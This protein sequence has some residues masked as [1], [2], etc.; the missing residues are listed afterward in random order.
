MKDRAVHRAGAS[1]HTSARAMCAIFLAHKPGMANLGH[2]MKVFL[3]EKVDTT[4]PTKCWTAS[5]WFEPVL[6]DT[7]AE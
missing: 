1:R 3:Y 2:A 7:T 5:G 6:G 4:P